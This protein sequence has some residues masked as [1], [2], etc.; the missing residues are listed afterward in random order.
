VGGNAHGASRL[1]VVTSKKSGVSRC[2]YVSGEPHAPQKRRFTLA[3]DSYSSGVPRVKRNSDLAKVT[4][5]TTGDAAERRHDWQWQ[6]ML[7]AGFAVA[8]YRTAPHMQPPC[9][10]WFK[11]LSLLGS[12]SLP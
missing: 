1:Q 6:T 7:F 8:E 12:A 10:S 9:M 2:S 4:H 3:D 11:P 5:A